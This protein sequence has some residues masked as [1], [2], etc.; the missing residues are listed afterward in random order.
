MEKIRL[1]LKISGLVQ[2]VF[3]RASTKEV[4]DKYNIQGLAKNNPDG[5]VTV[6]LEGDPPA[7]ERVAL[8]CEEGPPSA[9][10][11]LVQRQSEDYTAEFKDFKTL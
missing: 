2:G 11:A 1:R 5:S 3:F 8:W 9:D 6:I 4:A 7:V 10:V